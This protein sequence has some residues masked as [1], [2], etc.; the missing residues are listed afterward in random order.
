MEIGFFIIKKSRI[1]FGFGYF[2][3]VLGLRNVVDDIY[4]FIFC[5]SFVFGF[6]CFMV[7]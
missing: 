6:V 1:D 7:G 2:F 4:E 3:N 5:F